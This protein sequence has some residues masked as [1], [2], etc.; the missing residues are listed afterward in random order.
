MSDHITTIITIIIIIITTHLFLL[1]AAGDTHPTFPVG[2]RSTFCRATPR[3]AA[4]A[5]MHAE[6]SVS[7]NNALNPS[8]LNIENMY[9]VLSAIRV[10]ALHMEFV[11]D[12]FVSHQGV[13]DF[14]RIHY[15]PSRLPRQLINGPGVNESPKAN[16]TT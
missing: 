10:R 7:S 3:A 5:H 2:V 1:L 16:L 15:R 8:S 13:D 12:M 9:G 11:A 6:V 14:V 4:E